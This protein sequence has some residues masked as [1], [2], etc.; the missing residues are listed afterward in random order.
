MMLGST[1]LGE[2]KASSQGMRYVFRLMTT[3]KSSRIEISVYR[4][5]EYGLFKDELKMG[6]QNF[7]PLN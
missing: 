4:M 2:H 6:S 1:H 5:I 3:C 7:L